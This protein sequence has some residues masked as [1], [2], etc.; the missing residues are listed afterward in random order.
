VDP[1]V[2][3]PASDYEKSIALALLETLYD[4]VGIVFWN[5]TTGD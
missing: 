1:S 4:Q 3:G 2:I 5:Q